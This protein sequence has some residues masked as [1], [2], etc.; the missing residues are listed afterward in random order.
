MS[1][2]KSNEWYLVDFGNADKYL[3]PDGSHREEKADKKRANNGTVEFRSRDAHIGLISRRSDIECLAF[4]LI[5]WLYGQLPWM[6]FLAD[7]DKVED[8]KKKFMANVGQ[9]LNK[10]FARSVP[11]GLKEFLLEVSRIRFQDK[12][13]YSLLKQ[14]LTKVAKN[15]TNILEVD[16][17]EENEPRKKKNYSSE[18]ESVIESVRMNSPVRNPKPSERNLRSPAQRSD[19][20]LKKNVKSRRVR[21]EWSDSEE[22]DDSDCIEII[23]SPPKRSRTQLN[24]RPVQ[25][26]NRRVSPRAK[27]IQSPVESPDRPLRSI[28]PKRSPIQSPDR[29]VRSRKPIQSPLESPDRPVRSRKPIQ[30]PIESPD[31]PLRSHRPIKSPLRSKDRPVRSCR[32]SIIPIY[33]TDMDQTSDEDSDYQT[34]SGYSDVELSRSDGP[35][36]TPAMKA[37]RELIAKK[38]NAKTN[39]RANKK[40]K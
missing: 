8:A 38:K 21:R 39:K 9:S 25:E 2:S 1:K 5:Q 18:S 35:T 29:P 33:D 4:N 30:S 15:R 27:P 24:T 37:M 11:N 20:K 10:C 26:I 14:L 19:A 16:D 6:G 17:N 36:E 34:K 28:R 23:S 12:P 31:R 40:T 32:P 7:A 3:N 22:S 13:D